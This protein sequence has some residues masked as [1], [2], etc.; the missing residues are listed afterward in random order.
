MHMFANGVQ[1]IVVCQTNFEGSNRIHSKL[2]R[3]A[4]VGTTSILIP[5][6]AVLSFFILTLLLL[7]GKTPTYKYMEIHIDPS[8]S[9]TSRDVNSALGFRV[10]QITQTCT[11]F[12]AH[13]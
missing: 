2:G 3:T 12:Y 7:Q 10:K 4:K 11:V 13:G 9:M 8:R 6:G 5:K 1:P